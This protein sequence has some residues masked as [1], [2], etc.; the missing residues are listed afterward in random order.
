VEVALLDKQRIMIR[1]PNMGKLFGCD[2]LGIKVWF[3]NPIGYHC[4][5]TWE[6]AEVDGGSL[7][8]INPEYLLPV[9][10]D[11]IKNKIIT[12]F[13]D[14]IILHSSSKIQYPR[15]H[16]LVVERNGRQC[17]IGVEQV[18]MSNERGDGYFPDV[19]HGGTDNLEYLSKLCQ[20]GHQ[21]VLLFC[22]M[23]T[24][25]N[26]ISPAVHIDPQYSEKLQRAMA[27][28]V[29]VIA[30][31]TSISLQGIEISNRVPVQLTEGIISKF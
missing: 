13:A 4:L 17:Y 9:V 12:E 21:T 16:N 3:S 2:I 28:G 20:A 5:P 6:L 10:V 26:N 15:Y 24:G 23:H 25:I 30:Y 19:R 31:K 1:C 22:A 27:A 14:C 11:G 29:E 18:T 7:V 8:C